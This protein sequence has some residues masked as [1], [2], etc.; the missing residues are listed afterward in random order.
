MKRIVRIVLLAIGSLF[1]LLVILIFALL[2]YGQVSFKQTYDWP[3][4]EIKADTSPRGIA[5]GAYLVQSV[6]GCADCHAEEGQEG[7]LSGLS[8]PI[9][10][11]PISGVFSGSNLTP[12]VETGL[13]GWTDSEIAR[14]I[15]EGLNR[16]NTELIIM[17]AKN[18][19]EM[20]DEDIASVVGYLR[21][22]EPV[23][24]EIMPFTMNAPAKTLWTFGLFG[25][26]IS[27]Q[28]ILTHQDSP[29]SET[30]EYG[31][32]LVNLGGCRDCHGADLTGGEVPMAPPGSPPGWDI[33][34]SGSLSEWTKEEFILAM[35]SG[36]HPDG[37]LINP[38]MPWQVYRGM[39]E[40]DLESIY[41]YLQSIQK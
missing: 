10:Q 4:Y 29:A 31:A 9:Q 7:V 37:R 18:Y 19:R 34:S 15:R 13:G 8:Y 23:R 22:L 5:R 25:P 3:V 26:R 39:T 40:G 6:M 2:I 36:T 35:R 38:I 27:Q 14:A 20:S 16:D 11:G 24:S 41:Q 21:S 30:R 32:Y 33:T 12:D 17:P 28:P 1:G